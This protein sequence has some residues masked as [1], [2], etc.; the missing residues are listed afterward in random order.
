MGVVAVAVF[1][2]YL[3]LSVAQF[4]FRFL[5]TSGLSALL[6]CLLLRIVQGRSFFAAPSTY[7][8]YL[9][10]FSGTYLADDADSGSR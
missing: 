8:L 3:S 9:A 4:K 2:A 1:L 7:C 6:F 10:L 5:S